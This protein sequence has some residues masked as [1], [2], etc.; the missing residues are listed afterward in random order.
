MTKR[1]HCSSG[2]NDV[3]FGSDIFKGLFG[4]MFVD[5]RGPVFKTFDDVCYCV[6]LSSGIRNHH[7]TTS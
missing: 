2:A 1:V 6:K 4:V 3:P 7:A 5:M